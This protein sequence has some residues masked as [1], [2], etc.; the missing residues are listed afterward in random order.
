MPTYDYQCTKCE[1]V[2]EEFHKMTETPEII[3]EICGKPMKRIITVGADYIMTS[4]GTRGSIQK[5][6]K[7]S[8]FPTPTEAAQAKA[9]AQTKEI[10]HNNNVHKDPYYQ[11]RNK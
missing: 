8:A 7:N 10:E 4:D 11:F 9:N 5:Y 1:H 3:C 2:Q 6:K